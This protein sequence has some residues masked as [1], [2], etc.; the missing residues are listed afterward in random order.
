MKAIKFKFDGVISFGRIKPFKNTC[1]VSGKE[2]W[3]NIEIEYKP[4]ENILE[5]GSYREYFEEQTNLLIEDICSTVAEEIF[6]VI[7]PK[8][9]KVT[10]YLEGNPDLTD[11]KVSKKLTKKNYQK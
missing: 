7:R 3:C 6:K 1:K 2:E 5:I 8:W 10:V 4:D 11:W 9:L